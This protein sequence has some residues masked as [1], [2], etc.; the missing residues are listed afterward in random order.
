M[1]G[2]TGLALG[3]DGGLYVSLT[4]DGRVGRLRGREPDTVAGG[5]GPKKDIDPDRGT[6]ATEARLGH[7]R[8][9]AVG[10]LGDLFLT[11]HF[12]NNCVCRVDRN[13]M[14]SFFLGGPKDPTKLRTAVDV[15]AAP[16]GTVY[17]A[18]ADGCRV[19]RVAP[20][21]AVSVEAGT[22]KPG[23]SGDGGPALRA[24]LNA[25]SG[26]ALGPD[27]S[28]YIADARNG[29]VRR[30]TPDGIIDTV[31]GGGP[32]GS[33]DT[34]DGGPAKGAALALYLDPDSGDVAGLVGLA[35]GPDGA[36]YVS[37][38]VHGSVRRIAPAFEGI[39]DSEILILSRDEKELYVFDGVGRHLKTLD[40]A[41]GALV[42]RFVYDAAGRLTEVHDGAGAVTRVERKGG[43]PVA[44]VAPGGERTTLETGADGRLT[45][46]GSPSGETAEMEYDAGGLLTSF[47]DGTGRVARFR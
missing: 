12:N 11:Q 40:A 15:V 30:V 46:V 41:T 36:V 14:I 4:G 35:V 33:H 13:G 42:Y 18:D 10:P 43:R 8:G 6:V 16:D 27:G 29:R 19:W 2:P 23:F 45:R 44:L 39:S 7:L 32:A 21:G 1:N 9:L 37:D 31:A 5:P 26:L 28:L 25:P 20:D 22:G 3:P 38:V 34:G 24:E 17:A 47:K